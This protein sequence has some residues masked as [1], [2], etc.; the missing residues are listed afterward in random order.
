MEV[1][2]YKVTV[3]HLSSRNETNVCVQVDEDDTIQISLQF[4]DKTVKV[5]DYSYFT[6]F[7]KFRDTLLNIGY[8]LKCQGA[9]INAVQSGMMSSTDKIY[10]VELG[11]QAKLNQIV[12]IW[13]QADINEFLN[14]SLQEAFFEKWIASIQGGE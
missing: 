14:S 1:E 11:K 2:V 3:G 12:S 5:S 4:L 8:G 10:L 13:E 7:K 9:K 6:T